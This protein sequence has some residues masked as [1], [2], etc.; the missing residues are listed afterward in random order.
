MKKVKSLML[1]ATVLLVSAAQAQTV[2]D[3]IAKH[4]EALGGKEKISQV[5]SIY[6]ENSVEVMGNT[7]PSV[8][9]LV[10]GKGFKSETDAGGMKFVNT[11]TDKGG[12]MIN[13]MMG[14]SDAQD[15]PDEMYKSGKNQIYF[16]GA[17]VDYAAKGNKVELLGKDGNDYKIKVTA[18]TNESTYYIDG[19][20]YYV[21]KITSKGEMMGQPTDITMT[22]SD[23]KKTDFGIVIPYTR[24]A[25]FGQFALSYKTTKVEVNK[26]I[27][28]KIFDK[29][30]K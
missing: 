21:T 28:P 10:Q 1:A 22:F 3:I 30:A 11:Y 19:T 12:W 8:E 13:P 6:M 27:D 15:M 14:G 2:D 29:P 17:L 5:K 4:T 23:Y 18:G 16:G 9:T 7:S 26:E 24:S 20:T 25:D